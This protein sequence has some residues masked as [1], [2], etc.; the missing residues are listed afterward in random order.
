MILRSC[1]Y[2]SGVCSSAFVLF[3]IESG[4]EGLYAQVVFKLGICLGIG[5]PVLDGS[6]EQVA[7]YK[8]VHTLLLVVG[9]D[10]DEQKLEIV[11]MLEIH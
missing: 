9:V 7:E 10:A 1:L 8:G 11:F 2:T 3:E 6:L 5:E 4:P